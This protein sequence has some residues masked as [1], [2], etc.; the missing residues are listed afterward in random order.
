MNIFY[1]LMVQCLH[2]LR[3]VHES[4]DRL[5]LLICRQITS[6]ETLPHV[7]SYHYPYI[8]F[9]KCHE[10]NLAWNWYGR[11][12]SIPFLKSSIPFHSILAPPIF[13]TAISVPFQS[14][15]HSIPCPAPQIPV[16]ETFDLSWLTQHVSQVKH[17]HFLAIGFN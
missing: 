8:F 4:Y 2:C 3:N 5:T 16:C 10:R 1:D 6:C 9:Y 11:L 13:H 15:F 14:I 12:P 7:F 17:L